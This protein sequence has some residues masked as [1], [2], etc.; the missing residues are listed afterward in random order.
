[1]WVIPQIDLYL[2]HADCI[3]STASYEFCEALR[4]ACPGAVSNAAPHEITIQWMSL[5]ELLLAHIL[6]SCPFSSS[7]R[8]GKILLPYQCLPLRPCG[9]IVGPTV[10]NYKA[11]KKYGG[12]LS[13]QLHNQ[14]SLNDTSF[15]FYTQLKDTQGHK[16]GI[17]FCSTPTSL[18]ILWSFWCSLSYCRWFTK[19]M[20]LRFPR[21]LFNGSTTLPST[22]PVFSHRNRLCHGLP[23]LPWTYSC[24]IICTMYCV[25]L[26]TVCFVSYRCIRCVAPFI[27]STKSIPLVRRRRRRLHLTNLGITCFNQQLAA[28][29]EL[30]LSHW[31][32]C[33]IL[34]WSSL[35]CYMCSPQLPVSVFVCFG[36]AFWVLC[37]PEERKWDKTSL[38]ILFF[39]FFKW[40]DTF[41][42]LILKL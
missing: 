33:K 23:W 40:S 9:R 15:L 39:K 4:H 7:C 12:W 31:F 3:T 21:T 10:G 16:D 41:L 20:W 26:V 11:F 34:L 37:F 36:M 14:S 32:V 28:S 17:P 5:G 35:W 29:L 27:L 42:S 30:I 24:S 13:A 6:L 38:S 8:L 22:N 1:M 19:Q 25:N 18:S 2:C